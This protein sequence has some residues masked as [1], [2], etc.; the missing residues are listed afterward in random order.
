MDFN[1]SSAEAAFREEVKSWLS[2]NVPSDDD[3]WH[4]GL[5]PDHSSAADSPE[6]ESA[7]AD[8]Q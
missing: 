6:D 2:A 5:D 8:G 1:D 3:L 7:G 4:M